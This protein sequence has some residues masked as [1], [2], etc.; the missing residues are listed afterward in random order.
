MNPS[1]IPYLMH[2]G[3]CSLP[4]VRYYAARGEGRMVVKFGMYQAALCI[5]RMPVCCK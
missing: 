5:I 1:C 3:S 2:G 4:P